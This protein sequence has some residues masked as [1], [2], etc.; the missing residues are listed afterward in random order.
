MEKIGDTMDDALGEA[1]DKVANLLEL[2]YPGGPEIEK[3][4]MEYTGNSVCPF[5]QLLRDTSKFED[6]TF[7]YSGLKTSVLYF[8]KKNLDY[9][10]RI[11]EI[12]FHFQNTAFELV[13]RNLLKAIK[14][15]GLK[16]VVAAGGVMANETLRNRLK[17]ISQ[18]KNFQIYY[19][20]KKI[21]CTD[22]GAMVASLGYSL[23][24]CGQISSLDFAISPNRENNLPRGL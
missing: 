17:I 12:C 1:F 6:I 4:A 13:E 3:K 22:N 19:P 8:V 2:P 9:R 7:S 11:S 10:S 21:L 20:E 15:T 14:L 23:F 16:E 5:P 24:K 18:K